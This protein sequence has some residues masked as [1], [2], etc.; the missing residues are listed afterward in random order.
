MIKQYV[1]KPIPVYAIQYDGG[2]FAEILQWEEAVLGQVSGTIG[3]EA[4]GD[5]ITVETLEGVMSGKPGDYVICGIRGELYICD[6]GI[7]DESYEEY[8]GQ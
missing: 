5:K 7:F 2:N 1:K 4:E 8:T 3:L 6:Q